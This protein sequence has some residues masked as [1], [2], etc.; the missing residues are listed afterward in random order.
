MNMQQEAL[1]L[2]DAGYCV[3]PIEPDGSKM[4]ARVA[5]PYQRWKP[6][7]TQRPYVHDVRK[8][9]AWGDVGMAVI[10]GLVS[11]KLEVLDFDDHAM[12]GRSIYDAFR[13]R[14]RPDLWSKLVTYR[15]PSNGWRVCYRAFGD[16]TPARS[17]LARAADKSVI[18]EALGASIILVPGG[19][20]AAHHRG[21][22]YEYVQGHLCDLTTLI[23]NDERLELVAA[24]MSFGEYEPPARPSYTPQPTTG[25]T[26]GG[27]PGDDFQRRASWSDILEPAGWTPAGGR[28]WTRPGKD[29]GTSA[30][31]DY[32]EGYLHVFSSNAEPFEPDR[33]Y[34]KFHA[35]A[36]LYHDGDFK[37]AAA[38]LG[39]RGYGG[40]V[41]TEEEREKFQRLYGRRL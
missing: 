3:L 26:T 27:R 15:T 31:T 33:S 9:F 34:S 14:V 41:L 20:P 5:D 35:F 1:R 24:A 32:H 8:W 30:T 23:T 12:I 6:Y 36:L 29:S 13:L 10:G 38:E 2:Y 21:T 17:V 18:I 19:H 22:P 16:I 39:Q 25:S 37:A 7:K 4:V 11:D 40:T 28:S